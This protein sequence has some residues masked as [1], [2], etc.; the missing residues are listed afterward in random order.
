[1]EECNFELSRNGEQEQSGGGEE[2]APLRN[3][4]GGASPVLPG[5]GA[6]HAS[7]IRH[8]S[9]CYQAPRQGTGASTKRKLESGNSPCGG[10]GKSS[11]QCDVKCTII[12]VDILDECHKPIKLQQLSNI[13]ILEV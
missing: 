7:V 12:E 11:P 9:W 2:V 4:L 13:P 1:M 10:F 3:S 8:Q 5:T 6:R